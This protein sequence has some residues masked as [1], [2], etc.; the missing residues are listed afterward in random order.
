MPEPQVKRVQ[1]A[2]KSIWISVETNFNPS[3]VGYRT[4]VD[5]VS[6]K[7]D[8]TDDQIASIIG[9]IMEIFDAGNHEDI[10]PEP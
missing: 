7:Q 6:K 8:M 9:A 4:R 1:I 5:V 2:E 10:R 3:Q